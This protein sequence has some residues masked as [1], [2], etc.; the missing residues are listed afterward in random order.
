MKTDFTVRMGVWSSESGELLMRSPGGSAA[1]VVRIDSPA[2][3]LAPPPRT[4]SGA[5]F[6]YYLHWFQPAVF[7]RKR[8]D[9]NFRV[10]DQ[11][12]AKASKFCS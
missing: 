3:R 4:G 2:L 5:H 9:H 6:R 11:T 7:Q 1:S 12:S 8:L 10:P